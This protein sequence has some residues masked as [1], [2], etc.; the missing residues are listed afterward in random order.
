MIGTSQVHH[1]RTCGNRHIVKNG[2]NHCGSQQYLCR[3]CG[4]SRALNPQVRHSEERKSEVLRAYLERPPL[5]G[6][7]RD[8]GIP[9][10]TITAWLKKNS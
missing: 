7:S 2:R 5:R 8:F 9:R 3:A 1:C 4:S 10:N 6:L